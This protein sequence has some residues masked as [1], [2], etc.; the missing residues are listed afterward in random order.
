MSAADVASRELMCV[1]RWEERVRA[2]GLE[3]ECVL[4]RCSAK[5]RA[6]VQAGRSA[7]RLHLRH[8]VPARSSSRLRRKLG[9]EGGG[10]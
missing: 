4:R 8:Q 3:R 1:D 10:V 9:D 5:W 7:R 6:A 2:S